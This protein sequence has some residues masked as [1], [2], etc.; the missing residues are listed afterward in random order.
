MKNK[1]YCV[2]YGYY[3]SYDTTVIASS[4][5]AAEA[6]VKEVIGDD[7][8]LEGTWEVH[9]KTKKETIHK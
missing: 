5:E 2:S 9:E 6:K 7:V 3:T 1:R 8:T 4:K